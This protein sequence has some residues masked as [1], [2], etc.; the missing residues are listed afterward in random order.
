MDWMNYHH[1]LYFW[2]VVREGSVVK[3]AEVL[4]LSQPTVSSQVRALEA[5]LGEPLFSRV[6]RRLVP[7]E[8]GHVVFRYA[9]EIFS[10]GRELMSTVRGGGGSRRARFV[11]GVTDAMS[12]AIAY[13]LLSPALRLPGPMRM[14]CREDRSDRLLAALAVH[15]VDLVLADTPIPPTIRVQAYSHLL[16]ESDVT[17]FASPAL[18]PALRRRFPASLTG[19]RALW[20]GEGTGLRRQL[21]EWCQRE[22]VQPAIIGEFDDS[23]LMTAF[24]QHGAGVFAAPTVLTCELQRQHGVRAV[25]RVESV[26]ERFYAISP[27]RRI[28]HPAVAAIATQARDTVFASRESQ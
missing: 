3:A 2:T 9:D 5:S 13:R 21:D 20:P 16:G 24:G 22:G 23:A 25:A 1:L 26:R 15:D 4:R 10:L 28:K 7:T 8:T 18:A 14:I 19:V 11:V 27:E 6:G 17:F 12:K